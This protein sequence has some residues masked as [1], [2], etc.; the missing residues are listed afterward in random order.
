MHA[1]GDRCF[2]F[3]LD[4]TNVTILDLEGNY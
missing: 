2:V 1:S 3:Q 4:D